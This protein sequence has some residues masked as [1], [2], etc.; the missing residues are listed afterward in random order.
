MWDCKENNIFWKHWEKTLVWKFLHTK[1]RGHLTALDTQDFFHTPRCGCMKT[2]L[3]WSL[4]LF[5][6]C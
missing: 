2:Q 6:L 3:S 4:L 1:T 5:Y